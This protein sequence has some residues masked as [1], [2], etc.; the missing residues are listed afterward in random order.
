MTLPHPL[1]GVSRLCLGGNIFGWTMSSAESFEVL[2]AFVEGGGNFIDTA[3][4]YSAWVDGL[5]GGE[6]ETIIG[7]WMARRGNRD[8]IVRIAKSA[9]VVGTLL[10]YDPTTQKYASIGAVA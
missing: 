3:D 8:D 4:S 9:G 7:E 6:S 5:E 10:D 2:D 1:V